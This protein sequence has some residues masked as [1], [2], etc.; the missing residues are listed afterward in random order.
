MILAL[1]HEILQ[2]SEYL[3]FLLKLRS[4][5]IILASWDAAQKRW[6]RDKYIWICTHRVL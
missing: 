2:S 5:F 1:P 4:G 6:L 3:P